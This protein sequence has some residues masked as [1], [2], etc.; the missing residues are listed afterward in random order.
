MSSATYFPCRKI[1]TG[2][3]YTSYNADLSR[4]GL[5]EL[6]LKHI[7]FNKVREMDFVKYIKDLETV[8][9]AAAKQQVDIKHFGSFG[10]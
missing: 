7:D 1:P 8:G 3:F 4:E 9:E 6:G 5:D 10:S 2:I